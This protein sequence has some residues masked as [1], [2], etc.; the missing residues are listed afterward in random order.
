MRNFSVAVKR[1]GDS[2]KFLRKIVPGG[3][4]ESYGIEV[5]KLAGLPNKIIN[6]AKELLEQLEAENKKARLAAQQIESDQISFDKISDSIVTDRLRKTNIDEMTDSEL[7]DFVKDVL[8]Y[9]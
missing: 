4:D 6:R 9:V 8:K 1:Q 3:V 7:R 2:I 5:A